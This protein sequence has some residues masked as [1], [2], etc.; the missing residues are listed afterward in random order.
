MKIPTTFYQQSDVVFLARQLLG[1]YLFTYINGVKTGGYIVEA[2]AY[3]GINDKAAHSYGGR[4]TPRTQTMF[5]AGGI[6]YVYLCYGIHEMFNIVVST[7]GDPRAVLIRAIHP[8]IGINDMLARRKM[9]VLKHNI[10]SGPGSVAQALGINRKLNGLNLQSD[11]LWLEDEGLSFK[12]DQIAAVPRV[13]V[14]YAKEDALLPF[15]FYIKG[16][17]YVSKPN[18]A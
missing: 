12:D 3:N 1:K 13:G 7:E 14:A 16:D 8:T 10:T 15:R 17:A 5:A 11:V 9:S 18:K 6:A 2:E 4:L